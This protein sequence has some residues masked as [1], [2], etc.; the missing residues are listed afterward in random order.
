MLLS[1]ASGAAVSRVEFPCLNGRK[2]EE[3]SGREDKVANV[4]SRQP[5]NRQTEQAVR[6][7][8]SNV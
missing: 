6:L 7:V 2:L 5:S 8:L 4:R 3:R 1:N